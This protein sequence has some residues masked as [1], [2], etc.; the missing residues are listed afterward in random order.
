MSPL[1][2]ET[3]ASR[4]RRRATRFSPICVMYGRLGGVHDLVVGRVDW[5]RGLR[6]RRSRF[7]STGG[8]FAAAAVMLAVCAG[9]AKAAAGDNPQVR[10]TQPDQQLAR[11]I[12]LEKGDF[13]VVSAAWKGG[14]VKPTLEGDSCGGA[15]NA[16]LVLTGSA[17]SSYTNAVGTIDSDVWVLQTEQMVRLDDQR[18]P[19]SA[20]RLGCLRDSYSGSKTYTITSVSRLPFPR[21][22]EYSDAYRVLLNYPNANNGKGAKVVDDY[23]DVNVGRVEA[24][25]FVEFAYADRNDVKPVEL[26]LAKLLLARSKPPKIISYQLILPNVPTAGSSFTFGRGLSL[27]PD[28]VH[29]KDNTGPVYLSRPPDTMS[30]SATLAG[31]PIPGTGKGGCSWEL[32]ADAAGKPLL[33]TARVTLLGAHTTITVPFTV[34]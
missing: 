14:T 23:I 11:S 10:L 34:K 1:R 15:K 31:E 18:Q 21:L 16:D 28:N 25:L 22:G 3:N 29:G 9:L 13:P 8:C 12:L 2:H 17:S 5:G 26:E 33:V 32:P 27:R 4:D 30:C 19:A 24:S 20:V 6:G 7:V